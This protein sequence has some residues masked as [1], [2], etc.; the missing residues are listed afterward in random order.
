MAYCAANVMADYAFGS[1][2]PYAL[3]VPAR[4][5]CTMTVIASVSEAIYRA[6]K[7]EWIAS[8]LPSSR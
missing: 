2:P 3:H 8:S 1:N 5:R 6:A 7:Q 4:S